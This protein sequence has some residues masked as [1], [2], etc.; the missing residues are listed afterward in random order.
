MTFKSY[1]YDDVSVQTATYATPQGHTTEHHLILRI[2]TPS[3]AYAKQLKA[4]LDAY[5]RH[6]AVHANS[7]EAV[8]IRFFLSDAANQYDPLQEELSALG[9][10]K[11]TAISV[12]QQPPLDGT[13][14]AMW[15]YLVNDV[16]TTRIDE[17]TIC[18]AHGDYRHLWTAGM[19]SVSPTSKL[20]TCDIFSHYMSG[21]AS[22][23]MSLGDNCV[24]TWFF[25][26]D[27]DNNYAGVVRGRNDIFDI[28][29]LTEATHYIASTGIGGRTAD[30]RV[31]SLMDA[32][33]VQGIRPNQ[34][35]HL[36]ALTH[37]NRT[38][39]YGVRFERGSYVQYGD[40]R[41]IFISGTA[42]IDDK[43][44]VVAVGDIV[45]QTERMLENVSMLLS[46]TEADIHDMGALIVYLRDTADYAAVSEIFASRYPDIPH[47]ILLAPVC[48]PGWLI[49]MECMG[50]VVSPNNEFPTY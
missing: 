19:T 1:T 50:S 41:Q 8:F 20:Q 22:Q 34:I 38:S 45:R 26:N 5:R 27:V 10:D 48:R 24:R 25:V 21:L 37:L 40:R 44:Q 18:V 35:K 31:L 13:K 15:V 11:S 42:S 23:G 36:Y 3:L 46:E 4:I 14:I 32:Y 12:V 33:A 17:N 9:I 39:E 43:G 2:T 16:E 49:E 7:A 6:Q 28:E 30:H 29:G 47:V